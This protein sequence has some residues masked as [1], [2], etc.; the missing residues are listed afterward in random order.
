MK[1]FRQPPSW[2]LWLRPCV[3]TK[4]GSFFAD[5]KWKIEGAV[6][7]Q[8]KSTIPNPN[9]SIES[10]HRRHVDKKTNEIPS[11]ASAVS[12]NSGH[13]IGYCCF[14]TFHRIPTN[15]FNNVATR[16][17]KPLRVSSLRLIFREKWNQ[18]NWKSFSSTFSPSG[19][20]LNDKRKATLYRCYESL[21]VFEK[22]RNYQSGLKRHNRIRIAE[23]LIEQNEIPRPPWP[24]K[25]NLRLQTPN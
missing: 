1:Y 14:L 18:V 23:L 17:S 16:K 6:K 11:I 15:H 21:W 19:K 8:N 12:A 13:P 9:P 4:K 24:L 2:P 10:S 22:A 25:L 7:F 20:M 5:L 3:Q